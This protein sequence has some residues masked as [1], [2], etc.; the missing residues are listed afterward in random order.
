MVTIICAAIKRSDNI[1]IT[2]RNH[3]ECFKNSPK[4]TCHGNSNQ[5]FI[6][7]EGDFVDRKLAG[8]L[9]FTAGQISTPTECLFSED[10]TGDNLWAGEI[11]EKLRKELMFQSLIPPVIKVNIPAE[12]VRRRY[13]TGTRL[14]GLPWNISSQAP[15]IAAKFAGELLEEN[16]IVN[17]TDKGFE[18]CVS[19]DF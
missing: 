13:L 5:G 15:A 12:W 1:I 4:G 8:A 3:A 11:I 2:G 6:T 16:A 9:A 7:S 18:V 14:P 10:L 19:Y 17:E